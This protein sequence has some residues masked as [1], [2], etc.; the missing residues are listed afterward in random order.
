MRRLFCCIAIIAG[1]SCQQIPNAEHGT[2]LADS[3]RAVYASLQQRWAAGEQDTPT[4]IEL[5][6]T[7]SR[8]WCL[9]EL[10]AARTKSAKLTAIDAHIERIKG[11]RVLS[12]RR[13]H[14]L[15]DLYVDYFVREAELS[16]AQ[17]R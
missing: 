13:Q 4:F 14:S 16:K 5:M 6:C 1:S 3:A 9:A 15:N 8:R 2:E 7:W 11:V 17:T 12:G 10:D